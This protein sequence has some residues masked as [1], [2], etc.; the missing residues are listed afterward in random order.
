MTWLERRKRMEAILQT[1]HRRQSVTGQRQN[2]NHEKMAGTMGRFFR[3]LGLFDWGLRNAHDVRL[4][5]VEIADPAL[6]QDFDGFKILFLSDLHALNTPRVMVEA[7]ERVP[8]L[9]FDLC[10]LGGD[11][12]IFAKPPAREAARLMSPL[13]AVLAA[14]RP[15]YG[16]LGNHD[17]HDLVPEMEALGVEILINRHVTVERGGA[18]LVLIGLDDIHSFYTEAA[19]QALRQAPEGYRIAVIHSPEYADHAAAAG[20]NLYLA[21]HTHGGQICLPGGMPIF[22]ATQSH[23]ALAAGAWRHRGMRGY[24]STGLGSSD[25]P[26]RFNSRPEMALI[27]LR[28]A[29]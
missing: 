3:R 19:E 28:R 25:P 17:R 1:E 4:H 12:Q 15:L 6:P 13:L 16:V 11:Y 22:T 26:V 14:M 18:R 29:P 24:T 2:L 8:A 21:G 5:A 10:I 27:T 7:A 9:D 23:R 20:V